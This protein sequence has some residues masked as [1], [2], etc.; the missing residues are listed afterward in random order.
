[1]AR[2]TD[3]VPSVQE[4]IVAALRDGNY[5]VTA[6]HLSGVPESTYYAWLE[7]GKAGESPFVEFL[8]AVGAAQAEAEQKALAVIHKAANGWTEKTTEEGIGVNGP[9]SKTRE[10]DMFDWRAASWY[11]E[12]K[13]A[14]RWGT[15]I[16]IETKDSS[17]H[18]I[19]GIPPW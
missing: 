14:K 19:R 5:A 17:P 18:G 15:K 1:M 13:H 8:E 7:R 12:R 9:I 2:T 16:A 3:L 11:L 6:C 4:R 10:R